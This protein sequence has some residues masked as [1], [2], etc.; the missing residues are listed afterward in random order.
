ME[1]QGGG[2]SESRGGLASSGS[3]GV[4]WHPED[5]Q[6]QEVL[7]C[8]NM[9]SFLKLQLERINNLERPP[10]ASEDE[11]VSFV[12]EAER[13]CRLLAKHAEPFNIRTFY[14]IDQVD[15]VITQICGLLKE[16][17][18]N[19]EVDCWEE[20]EDVLPEE[21]VEKDREYFDKLLSY[22]LKGI[23]GGLDDALRLQWM[24]WKHRHD[25]EMRSVQ[26]IGEDCLALKGRIGRQGYA[27][28]YEAEWI[29]ARVA[30]RIP[31]EGHSL[32][33]V[34]VANSVRE[35]MINSNLSHPNISQ[36]HATTPYGWLVMELAD[37]DMFDICHGTKLD[38]Q[39]KLNLLWQASAGLLYLHSLFPPVVHAN[40][41]SS[42]FLA[43]GMEPSSCRVKLGDLWFSFEEDESRS[44]I[45]IPAVGT[46]E[47][48]APELLEGTTNTTASDVYGLGVTMYEAVT[49]AYPYGSSTL[50]GYVRSPVLLK[51][52]VDNEEPCKVGP[53]DCPEDM[54]LLMRRCC[55]RDPKERPTMEEVSSLLRK[56][57]MN[58]S[59]PM[60][61]PDQADHNQMPGAEYNHWM[62]SF[63]NLQLE[64]V[65]DLEKP[66]NVRLEDWNSFVLT[67]EKGHRLLQKHADGFHIGTFYKIAEVLDAVTEICRLLKAQ[68]QQWDLDCW[69]ELVDTLPLGFVEKDRKYLHKL[70]SY[71]LKGVESDVDDALRSRWISLKRKHDE[72]MHSLQ[73]I[74]E[75][76]L[77]LGRQ[78]GEGAHG[79][80]C[81]AEWIT[82]KVAVKRPLWQGDLPIEDFA[83]FVA[84]VVVHSKLRHP[85]VVEV[86]ATTPSGWLVMEEADTD[87]GAICHGN[88]E[89][90][91]P[92]TLNLIQ[93][94]AEGLCYLHSLSPATVHAD[95]KSSNFLVFGEEPTKSTVKVAD[96]GLAFQATESKSKTARLGGGTLEW[97][98]PEIFNG[99][100][101]ST[102]SDVFSFGVVLYEAVTRAHPYRVNKIKRADE[103]QAVM[104]KKKLILQE[105]PCKVGPGDCHADLLH[106]MRRCCALEPEDRPTMKEVCGC[107][108]KL[109]KE[110]NPCQHS[111]QV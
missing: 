9:M 12:L 63:L 17:T 78:I 107:L 29:L 31:H 65:N 10:A 33:I 40:V 91:W 1:R 8:H 110:W 44:K 83:T 34:T 20:L 61:F 108:R 101:S 28:R 111:D 80:V 85:N 18:Q 66:S 62:M 67:R 74:N 77:A 4:P 69:K 70:L 106:L 68:T 30:V 50:P 13:G 7:Y 95:V 32:S 96:F 24:P 86:Y 36:V 103:L 87:L 104:M 19:W 53:E 100:P 89:L 39:G 48:M 72:D 46:P 42:N 14:S 105:E 93:E 45:A 6:M 71:I 21:F 55:A 43:F 73:I 37:S 97:M 2:P 23:D 58:W 25:V 109:P 98:A 79:I 57:P 52:K 92:G 49:G 5:N 35:A 16:Y 51:K 38:W 26:I 22:I 11:W 27:P 88:Q 81:K 54:H 90:D 47:W 60:Q 75:A 84:E 76:D 99:K 94:A 3:S 59:P 15:T 64:R 41:K 82:V 56:L 102:A